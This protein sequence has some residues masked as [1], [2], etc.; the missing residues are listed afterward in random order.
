MSLRACLNFLFLSSLPTLLAIGAI[1]LKRSMALAARVFDKWLQDSI[2]GGAVY[3]PSLI[4]GA[5]RWLRMSSKDYVLGFKLLTAGKQG[6][7]L[8]PAMGVD[9]GMVP[10]VLGNLTIAV[11]PSVYKKMETEVMSKSDMVRTRDW[12]RDFRTVYNL[13]TL[14]KKY[15]GK[16]LSPASMR[17]AT[18][19][20]RHTVVVVWK[21]A[22]ELA[23]KHNM[24]E[25]ESMQFADGV[26]ENTQPM[27][28]SVDLP[29]YFRGSEF[30]KNLTLFQNMVN[31]NGNILWYDIL[32]E[33][34]AR[35][36]SIP[37][38]SY[39]LLMSQ[40]LPALVLGMVSR[41]RLP[42][43]FGEIAKDMFFY[44]VTPFTFFGRTAYN[45]SVGDWGPSRMIV[46][47]P[48]IEAGRLAGAI[49][50][51]K[52]KGYARW[53]SKKKAEWDRNYYKNII[54][55][56]LRTT[57]AVSGGRLPLQ[58]ITTTEGAINL[59][60]DETDDFRELVWSKYALKSK[61]KKKKRFKY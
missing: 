24:N 7:S 19:I 42:E 31:Q 27:G 50:K 12:D 10:L 55:Y 46:E 49:K 13:K 48:F 26:I 9:P 23:Q 18:Y 25:Q 43:D 20:D 44:L 58:A 38:M 4:A 29:N 15:A 17:M 36:I 61:K 3:D 39:R 21:S 8:L 22:Y 53:S 51:D 57:G 14:R 40:I 37:M 52:P 5:L 1:T 45:I 59:M 2:R 56:G 60:T 33:T 11:V 47:T 35:K 6:I 34:K 32:G 54:K 41:G 16:K 30:T 28:K